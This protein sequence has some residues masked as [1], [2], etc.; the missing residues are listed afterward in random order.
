MKSKTILALAIAGLIGLTGCGSSTKTVDGKSVL[1]STSIGNIYADDVYDKLKTQYNE[2]GYAYSYVLQSL[3]DKKFPKNKDMEEHADQY[4]ENLKAYVQNYYGSSEESLATVLSNY[5]G[6]SSLDQLRTQL[7]SNLQQSEMLK[8]YVKEHYD[9]VI[10]DYYKTATPRYIYLIMVE[11]ADISKPTK[12]EKEAVKKIQN[13]LK[14]GKAFADV[15]KEYSDDDTTAQ[16][17]GYIGL[18]DQESDLGETYGSEVLKA[19]LA[20]KEGETSSA[21]E[22]EKGYVILYCFSTKKDE[23]KE[24]LKNVD[25]SSP[26][27]TY[28]SYM[29]YVAFQSYDIKYDDED[30]AK[31]VKATIDENIKA[32]KEERKDS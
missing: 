18:V 24:E 4:I 13:L 14:E 5:F 9:E 22:G 16:A 7:I 27:L 29:Q 6:V 1:A 12:D 25:I 2:E 23:I 26:L 20:L 21:I 3:L 15:A 28:D 30:F 8:S 10:E 19:A 32:R 31:S 11:T 17:N